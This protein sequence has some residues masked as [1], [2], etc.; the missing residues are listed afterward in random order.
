MA[1]QEPPVSRDVLLG[2]GGAWGFAQADLTS[3]ARAAGAGALT[4]TTL[5][6]SAAQ[7]TELRIHG[8]SGSTAP[9]MLE[10][11]AAVQVAGDGTTMFYRRWTAAGGGGAGV[12]WK[13]E[14]YS[15]GG[16]TESPLASASWLVLA[17]F[18]LYNVAHFALPPPRAYDVEQVSRAGADPVSRLGRDGWHA[19]AQT[20]LRLLAFSATLQFTTVTVSILVSTAALQARN[21]HFPS[22]L[23]WY[24]QWSPAARVA[25]ALAGVAAVLGAMWLISVVTAHRYEARTTHARAGINRRWP[26]TQSGFWTGQQLVTRHRSLHAGGAAAL[27]AFIVA[28]PGPDMGTGRLAVLCLSGLV[29]LLVAVTLCLPLADR[30]SLS[31]ADPPAGAG[32]A[33]HDKTAATLWC[34]VLLA[35]GLAGFIGAFFTGEWP[36]DDSTRHITLPGFTNICAFLLA[37]QAL[38][39]LILA[40]TVWKLARSAPLQRSGDQPFSAGH[41]TTVFGVLA[42]CLGGTF[43]ALADL[44]ATRLLGTP[45]PSGI[46]LA[47]PPANALQIPWPVYAFAAAPVGLLAGLLIAA[48]WVFYTWVRHSR[49]FAAPGPGESTA[50]SPVAAFY[51]R[52]FGDADADGYQS[53]RRSI[54][55]AWAAGLL[56]GQA[57]V[58]AVWS[59]AGMTVATVLAEIYGAEA[60]RHGVLSQKLPGFAVLES[61]VG[62]FLAGLLIALLRSD[63]S[64][65]AQRRTIGALWDVGTFWPRAT[66][67]FAPPCYAE[68]AVPELV[69]RLRIL[70]GTV[71]PDDA[72]PAWA[73]I[74]AERRNSGPAESPQLSVPSGPVLLTG[75][76]Q[77]SIIATAVIGQLPED[78]RTLVALLTLACPARNLYGRAFPA[79]FGTVPIQTLGEL[80]Q[81]SGGPGLRRWKNLVRRTDYVGSWVFREPGPGP[82]PDPAGIQDGVD[83]PCW[84][85]VTVTADADPTPP[86]I[87]HHSAFW[88]DPRVTQLGR[89]LGS[90]LGSRTGG[91]PG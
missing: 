5:G 24:A 61:V 58:V 49:Q 3:P 29:L 75:Y 89:Y 12:P 19:V 65:P 59:A 46:Q 33:P 71:R 64:S 74:A 40:L 70:T 68:R 20:L 87:H 78:T 50:P 11:P 83:Q 21:A 30:H 7:F 31:L 52:Q 84:D 42:V 48:P 34:Y 88:P 66:H 73:Q 9:V 26:L 63:Y 90:L 82:G 13:L 47:T 69:D 38:L 76:S 23:S 22:W 44:F 45:V 62:L 43:G 6:D 28:R 60:S 57:A 14:A 17:P 86:P 39:L 91:E 56:I 10:H 51:G 72:D 36:V 4:D 80:L 79:Y 77:G 81:T 54:A 15:W 32:Q 37:V 35:A 2:L 85:P 27:T 41:L 16:L 1:E 8:V 55:R 18:M 25:L 67:P 53:S